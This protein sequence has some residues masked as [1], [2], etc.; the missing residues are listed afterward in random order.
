[1]KLARTEIFFRGQG[2]SKGVAINRPHFLNAPIELISPEKIPQKM[3]AAEIEVYRAAIERCRQ[4]ILQL[5]QQLER[6]RILEGAAILEGHLQILSDP[7]I[8]TNVEEKISRTEQSAPFVFQEIVKE[9]GKRFEKIREPFFRERYKDLKDL[10]NRLLHHLL[11]KQK[12]SP[13]ILTEPVILVSREITAS[14]VAEMSDKT[15]KGIVTQEGSATS[16]AAIVARAKGIPYVSNVDIKIIQE[17]GDTDLVIDGDT[18][19]VFLCPSVETLK[20]Y[21]TILDKSNRVELLPQSSIV[22]T[23]T[24][25]GYRIKILANV[26]LS[27]EVDLVHQYEG[28]GV[29]LI[30]TEFMFLAREQFPSEEEQAEIYSEMVKAAKGLPI[31][32]RTFDICGDKILGPQDRFHENNPY[33]GCRAIRLML[34]EQEVFKNQLRAILK[35]S[36]HGAVK[37]MFPMISSLQ[38]LLRTKEI[39]SEC[40]SEVVAAGNK[41]QM[42]KVGCMIEVP[43][44]AIISDL[45]AEHCHFLSIGTN[46][47]VQYSLAVD[48][49]NHQ[50]TSMYTPTDPCILRLIKFVVSQANVKGIPLSVCGEIASDP[51]MVPIL[52]GLGVHELSV[53][54]RCISQVRNAVRTTC[55]TSAASYVDHVMGLGTAVQVDSFLDALAAK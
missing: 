6:E 43:S 1:M 29:G 5:Q 53:A 49:G 27:D 13:Q 48:R 23:E 30:R 19:A 46:D 52:I 33:L 22:T 11:R 50:M 28:D 51:K 14:E 37:I 25:D 41:I 21:K 47:L 55:A 32:F 12:I 3:V 36:K 16:H 9:Y 39:L 8:T 2:L 17:H 26:D 38:E 31:T 44:A 42:P 4:D 40:Y 34:K 20:K 10:S 54:T 24:V 35:A 18:G 7:L 45:L 15:I